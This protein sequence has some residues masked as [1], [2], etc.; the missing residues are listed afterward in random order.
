MNNA[1]YS[2]QNLVDNIYGKLKL[3]QGNRT[4]H[5]LINNFNRK[6]DREVT[7]VFTRIIDSL[8][9]MGQNILYVVVIP[10][11][12]YYFLSEGNV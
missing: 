6:I 1:I 3:I 8:M 12:T 11:I 2:I 5:V 4:I 7:T 10:V 9:K